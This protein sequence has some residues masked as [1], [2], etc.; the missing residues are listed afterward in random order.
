MKKKIVPIVLLLFIVLFAFL[1]VERSNDTKDMEIGIFE[2]NPTEVNVVLQNKLDQYITYTG[3]AKLP[4]KGYHT[5]YYTIG[6]PDGEY[7]LL[8]SELPLTALARQEQSPLE[9]VFLSN[10]GKQVT[11]EG[12][13]EKRV[14]DYGACRPVENRQRCGKYISYCIMVEKIV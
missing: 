9:K 6:G 3:I 5:E 8:F 4:S 11:V 2:P 12:K 13:V 14:D 7:C 10:L 1:F